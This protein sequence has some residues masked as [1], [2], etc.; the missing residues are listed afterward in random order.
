MK[1]RNGGFTLIELVVVVGMFGLLMSMTYQILTTTIEAERRVNR[2]TRTGKIGEGIL[3]QMRR[4][5]QGVIWRNLGPQVFRGVDGGSGEGAEDEVHFLTTSPVPEPDDVIDEWTG[6]VSS[7]G[8]VLKST[9][10]GNYTLFR[11]VQWETRDS[12]LEDGQY[13]EIYNRVRGLEIN[14]L[15]R[16]GEWAD[17]WDKSA[18]LE[19]LENQNWDT[20][21]PYRDAKKAAADAAA[22]LAGEEGDPSLLIDDE[23]EEEE[24]IPLPI[25]RAVQIILTISVGDERGA[26]LDNEGNPILERV[27]TIVPLICAEVLRVEDPA[28]SAQGDEQP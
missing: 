10:D 2:D 19:A 1:R 3:T 22:Q 12:P 9:G 11:R 25:P 18:E 24:E 28:E 6:S 7:V 4:D 20:F 23:T 17:E 8:Y 14:Y 15:D 26:Y 5:L 27:S 13:Y 16:E 21:L